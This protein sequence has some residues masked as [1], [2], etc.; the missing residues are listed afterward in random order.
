MLTIPTSRNDSRK[1]TMKDAPV[2]TPRR[3]VE[4]SAVGAIACSPTMSF[5]PGS[6]MLCLLSAKTLWP[7]QPRKPGKLRKII[8][9]YIGARALG[10]RAARMVLSLSTWA[11]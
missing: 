4:M 7:I 3:M 10:N 6:I 11:R 5:S 8:S 2:M 1:S 9:R